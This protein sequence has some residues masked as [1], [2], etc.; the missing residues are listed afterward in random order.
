MAALPHVL[1]L[2]QRG[3]LPGES[4]SPVCPHLPLGYAAMVLCLLL[5]KLLADGLP[6]LLQAALSLQLLKLQV[7]KLFGSCFQHLPV[8]L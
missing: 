2:L 7:L 6:L 3:Y 1:L 4:G 8:L 5:K